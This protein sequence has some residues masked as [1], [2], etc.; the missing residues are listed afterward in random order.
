MLDSFIRPS[1]HLTIHQS[2][3]QLILCLLSYNA[4]DAAAVIV[5]VV[6]TVNAVIVVF[7]VVVIVVIVVVVPA[8]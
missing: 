5:V 2:F 6:I 8:Y 4:I 1:F 7:V 3:V